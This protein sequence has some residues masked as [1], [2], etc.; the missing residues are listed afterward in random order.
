MSAAASVDDEHA[1]LLARFEQ[2]PR[3]V[4]DD[5]DL[6]RRGAWVDLQFQVG[7]D[8][9]PYHLTVAGGR[10]ASLDRGPILMASSRFQIQ[11]T[12]EAWRRFWQ[13]VPEPGWHDLLAL[14]KRGAARLDGDL[15][16][17]LAN[18]QYFKDVLAAPRRLARAG[19]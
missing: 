11:A 16:P 18:L 13:P 12:G 5:A 17:L 9:V 10:I 6:V 7:L 2:L 14:T 8:V 4:N 3:L 1:Q 15:Q 19:H